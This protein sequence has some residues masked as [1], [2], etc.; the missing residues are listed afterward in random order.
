MLRIKLS[1]VYAALLMIGTLLT[2]CSSSPLDKTAAMNPAAIYQEAKDE[3]GSGQWERAINLL[4][5]LEGRAA[6]TPLAQQAQLD[7]AY[8]QFKT[9]N[10]SN[11]FG[12]KRGP[13]ED[14]DH[15]FM[16]KCL[17]QRDIKHLTKQLERIL[18]S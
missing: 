10:T 14:Q 17:N 1:V 2:A 3:M 7:K 8:A 4:E 16:K 9:S 11:R 5:R 13:L 15:C 18:V 12:W 6:G